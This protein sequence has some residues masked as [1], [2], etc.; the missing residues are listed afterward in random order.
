MWSFFTVCESES[1][2]VVSDSLWPHGLYS[3]WN[4]PVFWPIFR[5]GPFSSAGDLPNPWIESRSPTL[6]VHSLPAEPQ[7]T[8]KNTG[9]GSLSLLQWIFLTQELNRGLLHYR[10]ILYQLSYEGSPMREAM[11]EAFTAYKPLM[12]GLN[13]FNIPDEYWHKNSRQ[14]TSKANTVAHLKD[15]TP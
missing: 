6:Q 15:H 7:G 8:P 5:S 1:H 2:S 14:N 3:P 9:E 4:S 10:W 12:F 13:I 11:R